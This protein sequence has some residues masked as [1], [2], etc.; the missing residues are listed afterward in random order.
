M[1]T[2]SSAPSGKGFADSLD[3]N[4]ALEV[5][6]PGAA[7]SD[8]CVVWQGVA[9]W[10]LACYSSCTFCAGDRLRCSIRPLRVTAGRLQSCF[11]FLSLF[12]CVG[13]FG[14]GTL[15]LFFWSEGMAMYYDCLRF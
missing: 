11:C 6:I 4:A 5:I 2:S 7:D 1:R 13:L 12:W 14:F 10:R 8:P 9:I 15:L 3:R